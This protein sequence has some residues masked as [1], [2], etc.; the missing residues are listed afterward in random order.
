MFQK[1]VVSVLLFLFSSLAHSEDAPDTI[2]HFT[3]NGVEAKFVR[4][5]DPGYIILKLSSGEV[6]DL[7]YDGIEFETLFEWESQ[8]KK[9]GET[10]LF[11]LSYTNKEGVRVP[12]A[13]HTHR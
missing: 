13:G 8:Q 3:K 6:I 9:S 1:I 10:R 2:D 4:I 7:R 5:H 12:A 11:T